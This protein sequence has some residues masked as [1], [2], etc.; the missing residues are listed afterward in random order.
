MRI[1]LVCHYFAPEPGAPQA[2]LLETARVWAREGHG[3]TVVTC[4]PNHPTG[5]LEPRDRGRIFRREDRDGIRILRCW[6]YATPN[7]GILRK[8]LGHLSFMASAAFLGLPRVGRPDAVV[9]SSP[10]FFSIVPAL[11]F[12][13]LW[14]RPLVLE[15]RDLWP[16]IFTQLGV[17]RNRW[18]IRV[19]TGLELLFYRCA[20]R[21]VPVTD[22]FREDIV[23]R[24]ID[25]RKV[26]TITNGVDTEVFRPGRDRDAEK[27]RRG[28]G[29]RFVVLY[30]GAHGLSHGLSRILELADR[31]RDDPRVLFLFVGEGA[32]KGALVARARERALPNVEFRPPVEKGEVPGYYAAAD[33]CLVP[34]RDVPLFSTFIP[35]KMFEIMGSGVP[36]LASLSG[37]AARILDR[38]GAAIVVP[39]EDV[40]ALDAGLRRLRGDPGLRAVLGARGAAFVR[41]HYDR[42]R[43][44]LRYLGLIREA[45]EGR[46]EGR[47]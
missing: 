18:I 32:E 45:V 6:V 42:S 19:L 20:A 33:V 38:S 7:R 17:L 25:P 14:R 11:L 30:L 47:P 15:V 44:A 21:V 36:I 16:A 8:T 35:S 39:P 5:I 1:V 22:G 31:W 29:G 34:L 37:E 2:R 23:R 40:D 13:L 26:I 24:G 4:F 46:R 9:V 12:S 41:E 3:V 43:L 28:L 10:T 27:A